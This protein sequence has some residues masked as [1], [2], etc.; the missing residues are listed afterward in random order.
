[1]L[2]KIPQDDWRKFAT[3]KAFYGFMWSFPGKQL[4]FMGEE[5]AQRTEWNEDA[6]WSGGWT[7]CGATTASGR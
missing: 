3:L 6:G 4:L 5:F 1:M 2:N 7:G